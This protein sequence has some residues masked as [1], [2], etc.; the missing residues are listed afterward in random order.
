MTASKRRVERRR[1][2]HRSSTQPAGLAARRGRYVAGLAVL[3]A[4]LLAGVAAGAP[5]E[6]IA[7][8]GAPGAAAPTL[9]E[10]V[11][12][13]GAHGTISK[14]LFGANLLWPYGAGGSFDLA[15]NSFYPAF[16][17]ALKDAGITQLRWPGGTT[18]DSFF[19]QRAIGPQRSRKKN[20]PYGMQGATISPFVLDGPIPS[21]VGPDE[22]G[23]LLDQTGAG[24]TV[25]VNFATGTLTEAAGLVAYLTA[26]AVPHP[27]SNPSEPSYWAAMRARNGHRAPYPV[28]WFEVGNEQQAPAEYGWRAGSLVSLGP[29]PATCPSAG[30]ATCL[31]AFGGTTRFSHQGVGTFAD[32]LPQASFSTGAPRQVFEVYYPPVVPHSLTV[33]VAGTTWQ[34][35]ASLARAGA[36]SHVYTLD[37]RDGSIRFGDGRH[38][39]V[40]PKGARILVDYESGPH[41]GFVELYRAMKAMNPKIHVC[42]TEQTDLAFALVMGRTDPYDCVELH[43]YAMP[44][45]VKEGLTSYMEE[46]LSFPE[47][48]GRN[49]ADLQAALRQYSGRSVP[50]VLTEYGQMVAPM[51]KSDPYFILSLDNGLLTAAQLIE[52]IDHGVP[53]AEKYLATSAPFLAGDPRRLSVES[54]LHVGEREGLPEWDPGL[55]IDS[56]M[57]AGPGPSFVS[58]PS[59]EAV[60][61]L[62]KLAAEP[63][64]AVSVQNGPVLPLAS[65]APAL[66][67]TAARSSAGVDLVVVNASPSRSYR[68]AVVVAGLS[69]KTSVQVSV[70]DGPSATSFNTRAHPR[71]VVTTESLATVPSGRFDWTFPAHSVSL[72]QLR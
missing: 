10:I 32:D 26:P 70:L 50:V 52:W 38:G 53:L 20:E 7:Q 64:L 11:V 21:T 40:P 59:G 54:V 18:A 17:S 37:A 58:E 49:V 16:V 35:V 22:F 68:A 72:L 55:S 14:G 62:S 44:T 25:V 45:D 9:P 30:V 27:S 24:G 43:E 19:W 33:H 41:A 46:L 29:H 65:P 31:Y 6:P 4:T 63:R 51:P 8:H 15:T 48:E 36:R 2:R 28:S 5:L 1:S 12:A 67:S 57:I 47:G 39:A 13:A 42:E 23:R 61:L 3:G 71:A 69:H 56:A 66:L 34:L 60:D